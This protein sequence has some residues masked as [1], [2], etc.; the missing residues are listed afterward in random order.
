[1]TMQSTIVGTAIGAEPSGTRLSDEAV[2]WA[3]GRGISRPTL[4]RLGVASG[5]AFFPDLNRK[6][7]ALFFPYPDGWK[8]RAFPEKS[9][10]ASKG[11]KMSFWGQTEAI[12]S[13]KIF[14]TE[15]ELDRCAMVEAGCDPRSVISVPNGAKQRTTE[16][17]EEMRGYRYVSDGMA[18]GLNRA[19]KFVWCGDGDGPGLS[20]RSDMAK[21]IGAARF[22]F[23]EW[24]EGC[25]DPNDVLRTEGGAYLR[26]LVTDGA[27]PW[28]VA[29]LYRINELPEPAPLSLW[30]PGFPEWE[31]KVLLAPRTVSVVTGHPGHGKTLFWTQIWFQIVQ[32]YH[33]IVC[34]ASFE[35]RPKPHLRR[36]L[37]SLYWRALEKNISEADLKKSDQWI[38]DHYL[39]AVHPEQRPSLEWIL[40]TAE[41]A[42]VRHGARVIQIDPWNRLEAARAPNESETDYIGRC[43]RTLHVFANDMNC[44]VQIIAHPAKM[45][46]SRRGRVPDLEDIAGSKNWENMVDQGFVVH[47]P[48]MFDGR[49]RKTEATL[50]HKKSRFE[51]LG[52]PC[53]LNMKYSVETA[54][55]ASID[56]EPAIPRWVKAAADD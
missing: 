47:R 39:F 2:A 27:L 48:Q 3:K 5:T 31:N 51:E 56:Y 42:I 19:K 35:T 12:G 8:A 21:I 30:H 26:E 1:M 23:V 17:S 52:Y 32:A 22:F 45:D 49:D 43:L 36:H 15:G 14:I 29:G 37:R 54:R 34:S 16:E 33:L 55:Y 41:V 13:E 25:K 11:L 53:K 7:P 24:P 40:D 9:F 50:Y 18:A 28:P 38:N 10:V 4:E 6:A 46:S 20:L 44:H